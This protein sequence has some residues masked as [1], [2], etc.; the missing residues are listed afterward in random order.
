M[1]HSV[2][3][4]SINFFVSVRTLTVLAIKV[5]SVKRLLGFINYTE[6]KKINKEV[7]AKL[8]TMIISSDTIIPTRVSVWRLFMK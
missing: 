3:V 5:I 4:C 8:L 7:K 6:F 2:K 1:E